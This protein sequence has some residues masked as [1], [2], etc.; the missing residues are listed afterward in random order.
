MLNAPTSLMCT[1]LL[2]TWDV[3]L[4]E[5]VIK[6]IVVTFCSTNYDTYSSVVPTSHDST[7]LEDHY[8]FRDRPRR[9]V[10]TGEEYIVHDEQE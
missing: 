4:H 5:M 3:P 2:T 8:K 1:C 7:F 6:Q 9:R 10:R